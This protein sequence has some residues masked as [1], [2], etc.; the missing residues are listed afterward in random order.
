MAAIRVAAC[1]AVAV[2][3]L[4]LTACGGSGS[5]SAARTDGPPPAVADY[6]L[7]VQRFPQ[8]LSGRFASMPVPMRGVVGVP[9]G[10]GPAPVV[11]IA[12]GSFGVGC[13]AGPFDTETWPCPADEVRSDLGMRYLVEGLARRGYV[14]IAPSV[15]AAYTG[16]WGEPLPEL[17]WGQVVDAT[18]ESLVAAGK[19]T[20][21]RFGV[22]LA[23][24]VDPESIAVVGHS[25]S[26]QL[27]LGWAK[28]REGTTSQAAV[29]VG[30]GPVKAVL[31][32][33]PAWFGEAPLPDVPIAEVQAQCDGDV[34]EDAGRYLA[35]VGA[36]A[37]R[38]APFWDV[39]LKGANHGWFNSTVSGEK[40]ED[41][42]PVTTPGCAT[43]DRLTA[44]RQ[45]EWL[46]GFAADVMAKGLR[47][48]QASWMTGTPPAEILGLPVKA[49]SA[50]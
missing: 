12:H 2:L 43:A 35:L 1:A 42:S 5:G 29:A 41:P 19:G 49:R 32:V 46:V 28:A 50:G 37:A 10:T 33:T 22:P 47:G 16:G 11:V 9:A 3:I 17:R 26:G 21:S 8:P 6:D 13:P 38:T 4:C 34:G 44:A 15:N 25:R 18:L 39:T 31:M 40:R 20:S 36:D 48:E 45:Q 30:K 24:R 14:A 7:G 23:G 27:A